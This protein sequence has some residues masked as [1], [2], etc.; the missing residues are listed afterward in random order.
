[1]GISQES[2][3]GFARRIL[4][5]RNTK[6]TIDLEEKELKEK[7]VAY[8]IENGTCGKEDAK[9]PRIETDDRYV[10][11]EGLKV[12]N[13]LQE[14]DPTLN[15]DRVR[16]Y[17]SKMGK[18]KQA[19]SH[20]IKT[21]EVVDEAMFTKLKAD[22]LVTQDEIERFALLNPPKPSYRLNIYS[23]EDGECRSC[24]EAVFQTDK[25]CSHCGE[26]DPF[27]ATLPKG[28]KASKK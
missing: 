23:K 18:E 20:L 28:K 19:L 2:F 5:L 8:V 26:K 11:I 10:E 22:G 21:V 15:I 14:G 25:F 3:L 13:C 7:V 17:I 12:H 4:K 16:V 6:A 24:K 9:G 1:M 27:V